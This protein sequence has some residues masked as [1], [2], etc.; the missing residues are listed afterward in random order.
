MKTE[1][2]SSKAL[3]VSIAQMTIG[4]APPLVV[5]ATTH[6]Q[7]VTPASAAPTPSRRLTTASVEAADTATT[8]AHSAAQLA[9]GNPY[10][11]HPPPPGFPY[12]STGYPLYWGMYPYPYPQYVPPMPTMPLGGNPTSMNTTLPTSVA[13]LCPS[14]VAMDPPADT[15]GTALEPPPPIWEAPASPTSSE[16]AM[17]PLEGPEDSDEIEEEVAESQGVVWAVTPTPKREAYR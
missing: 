16:E 3:T 17:P 15:S 13:R 5:A 4:V 14:Q 12:L 9:T 2:V 7:A 8:V 6:Q 11:T 10:T 1:V